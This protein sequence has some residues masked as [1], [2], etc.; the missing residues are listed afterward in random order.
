[1]TDET[2]L[3]K[4]DSTHLTEN[5]RSKRCIVCGEIKEISEFPPVVKNDIYNPDECKHCRRL[6]TTKRNRESI[7]ANPSLNIAVRKKISEHHKKVRKCAKVLCRKI[8]KENLVEIICPVCGCTFGVTKTVYNGTFNYFGRPPKY[9][10]LSCY[11][12][13]LTKKWKQTH[14]P[15]AKKIAELSREHSHEEEICN[16]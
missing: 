9:C 10:S 7:K 8:K 15:Y 4:G 1:M 5:P 14:S 13:S 2:V 6:K 16:P 11:H 3:S 12:I